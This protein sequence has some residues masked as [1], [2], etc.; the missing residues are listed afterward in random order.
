M[1]PSD[2]IQRLLDSQEWTESRIAA[3]V[4]T[5]QPTVNRIKRGASPSY[6]VGAAIVALVERVGDK[7]QGKA[8]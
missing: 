5:S 8:A 3:E 4:G 1:K 2:A 7:P 6:E